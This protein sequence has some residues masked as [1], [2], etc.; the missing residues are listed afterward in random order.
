MEDSRGQGLDP[1]EGSPHPSPPPRGQPELPGRKWVWAGQER[2]QLSMLPALLQ[3]SW[4][5]GEALARERHLPVSEEKEDTREGLRGPKWRL[6]GAPEHGT[7]G[8]SAAPLS[9]GQTV[10]M[11]QGWEMA[12]SNV[13]L[14][15]WGR[16]PQ[17]A[18]SLPFPS[19]SP[20]CLP[21]G[22]C[23]WGQS[24]PEEGSTPS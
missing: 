8:A 20:G 1:R 21:G 15:V 12:E 9:R 23:P 11:G 3:D 2:E 24:S 14:G 16:G 5:R 17:R 13:H 10:L 22:S 7:K 19:T 6:S 18:G 4:A